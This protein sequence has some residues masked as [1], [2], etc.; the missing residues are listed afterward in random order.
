MEEIKILD[1]K[2]PEWK[3][4]RSGHPGQELIVTFKVGDD[5]FR[6]VY[7]QEHYFYDGMPGTWRDRCSF[8]KIERGEVKNSITCDGEFKI[9][10]K[11]GRVD[12]YAD[13]TYKGDD[14]RYLQADE[15]IVRQY[16]VEPFVERYY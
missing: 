14:P 16:L 1:I 5:K 8:H 9:P 10:H 2:L 13:H 3:D 6:C 4:V 7:I 12:A 11:E 15:A